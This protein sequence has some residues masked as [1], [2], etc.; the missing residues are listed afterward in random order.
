MRAA[1]LKDQ[2]GLTA[3]VL[4]PQPLWLD[5]LEQVLER[6]GIQVVAKTTNEDDALS[7]VRERQPD[8]LIASADSAS[9][10]AGGIDCVRCAHDHS[11]GLT[12]VVLAGDDDP[13]QIEAAFAAGASVYC[14]KRAAAEDLAVAIRQALE[15]SI[16]IA[17]RQTRHPAP[18]R[19]IGE[20]ARR[21]DETVALT[22]RELEILRLVAEGHPNS[23]VAKMLYVT[24]PTVKFHLS[25]IYRKLN[26]SNRTEAS[27]R[28][29]LH[30]LLERR[31]GVGV[32][33][34]GTAIRSTPAAPASSGR[35][36]SNSPPG[37]E[38][39]RL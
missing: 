22:R 3:V 15:S 14:V 19:V 21:S 7:C 6:A 16:F 1:S 11:P 38:R 36:C 17:S 35:R 20:T 39:P 24:V 31:K 8:V 30:G 5:A 4:D 32:S 34:R 9:G 37:R 13:E 26:V 28:A 18:V 29:Q 2:R 12:S 23:A 33:P 27:R 10:A 25:N